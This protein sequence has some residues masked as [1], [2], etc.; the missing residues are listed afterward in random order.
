[1]SRKEICARCDAE[2]DYRS[3]DN[4]IELKDSI[5]SMF[6]DYVIVCTDCAKSFRRLYSA[7]LDQTT[8]EYSNINPANLAPWVKDIGDS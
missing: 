6:G 1:M 5:L 4:N 2:L 8:P 3:Y 7:W